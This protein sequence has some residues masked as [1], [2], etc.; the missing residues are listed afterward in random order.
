MTRDQH[1]QQF[2]K[3][4]T[5]KFGSKFKYNLVSYYNSSTNVT[6][7]CPAH[8]EFIAT[9]TAFLVRKYGCLLCADVATTKRHT[10]VGE[11]TPAK[12]TKQFIEDAKVIFGDRYDYSCTAYKAKRKPVNIRCKIHGVFRIKN[13][14]NHTSGQGCPECLIIKKIIPFEELLERFRDMHGYKYTYDESSYRG[15]KHPINITCPEHGVF[16]IKAQHH[17]HG[18]GCQQCRKK[19]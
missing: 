2:I 12:T 11:L 16:T 17:E 14:V 1:K 8:G 9:P 19:K 4:A 7:V 15:T 18:T 13:A 10:P 3:R 6:I 5:E